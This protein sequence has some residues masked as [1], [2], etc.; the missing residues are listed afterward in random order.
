M[1]LFQ[2][3]TLTAMLDANI[4]LMFFPWF[5]GAKGIQEIRGTLVLFHPV[6]I[7]FILLVLAGIWL[8]Q[9][10]KWRNPMILTGTVG[11]LGVE[12]YRFLTWHTETI[13]PGVDLLRCFRMTYPVC[14]VGMMLT[15]A[16]LTTAVLFG[17][18]RY[19]KE[20]NAKDREKCVGCRL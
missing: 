17:Y 18:C 7:L 15:V 1:S 10:E 8:K 2:K 12:I 11:I 4:V 9:T 14:Y 20:E 5:G 16:M 6:T 13:S 3:S 19:K